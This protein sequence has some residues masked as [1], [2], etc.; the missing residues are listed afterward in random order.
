MSDI[1]GY[2]IAILVCVGMLVLVGIGIDKESKECEVK[3]G[4]WITHYMGGQCLTKEDIEK[5]RGDE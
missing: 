2:L 3:G 5:L 1:L 4:V